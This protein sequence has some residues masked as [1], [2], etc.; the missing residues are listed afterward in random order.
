VATPKFTSP[1]LDKPLQ[2][3]AIKDCPSYLNYSR[4][5]PPS[6]PKWRPHE[7][8]HLRALLSSNLQPPLGCPLLAPR[9][10]CAQHRLFH[11]V[12]NPHA[13]SPS[14]LHRPAPCIRDKWAMALAWPTPILSSYLRSLASTQPTTLRPIA[15]S[16][17]LRTKALQ[18][19]LSLLARTSACTPTHKSTFSCTTTKV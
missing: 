11:R 2:S 5:R 19:H 14:N 18:T 8:S 1:L 3:I 9:L 4:H 6:S 17:Q 16:S 15:A 10:P 7:L 13:S 12:T